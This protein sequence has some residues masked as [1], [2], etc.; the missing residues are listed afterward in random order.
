MRTVSFSDSKVRHLLNKDFVNTFTNTTGD[1]TAGKSIWHQPD[2]SPGHCARGVGGQNV[3]TIFMTPEGKIFHAANGFLSSEDLLEEANFAKDL[4]AQMKNSNG[5][6]SALV[7]Q[8]HEDRL[9]ELGFDADKIEAATSGRPFSA[10]D[11]A[12]ETE[13]GNIFAGKTKKEI[14][15][16]NAFSINHPMMDFREFENDPAAL[17]GKGKSSFVST[18]SDGRTPANRSETLDDEPGPEKKETTEADEISDILEKLKK[19]R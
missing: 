9:E 17:V 14:L 2:D 12:T 6:V 16:G 3:Q 8:A 10:F 19:L 18:S 7:R 1:P 13:P 5:S 11:L 15:M 4:F